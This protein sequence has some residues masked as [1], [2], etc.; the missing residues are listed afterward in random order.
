MGVSLSLAF[1]YAQ[2]IIPGFINPPPNAPK[3]DFFTLKGIINLFQKASP[4][5]I[6]AAWIHY[7]IFDLWTGQWIANDYQDNIKNTNTTK[8]YEIVSLFF[9][10]MFGPVGLAMYLGGKYT[11]LPPKK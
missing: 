8:A 6:L 3:P 1:I 10:L 5:T 7:L 4:E 11:F 9:T 2:E